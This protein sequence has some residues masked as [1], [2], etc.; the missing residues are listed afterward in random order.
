[1]PGAMNP[2][3]QRSLSGMS[4]WSI[5]PRCGRPD[6]QQLAARMPETAKRDLVEWND[7]KNAAAYLERVVTREISI[8]SMLNPD[9][10]IQVTDDK[11]FNEYFLLRSLLYH[12]NN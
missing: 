5:P 4:I 6:A 12:K 1:M 7:S 11:P 9:M 8:P 10:Q 2:L 3:S